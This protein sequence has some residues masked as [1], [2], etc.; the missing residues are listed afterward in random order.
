ML[1][2]ASLAADTRLDG[3]FVLVPIADDASGP[4]NRLE[5]KMR[6]ECQGRHVFDAEVHMEHAGLFRNLR[7]FFN[8]NNRTTPH[9]ESPLSP[10]AEN[11]TNATAVN[12]P[13]YLKVEAIIPVNIGLAD[14]APGGHAPATNDNAKGWRV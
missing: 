5:H 6:T 12:A 7:N 4:S 9:P 1:S 13:L 11:A 10:T 14:A 2:G 8:Q 3:A